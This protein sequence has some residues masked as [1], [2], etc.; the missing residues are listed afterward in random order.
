MPTGSDGNQNAPLP[1]VSSGT[2][3]S[4]FRNGSQPV[5]K[6]RNEAPRPVGNEPRSP[7]TIRRAPNAL[8]DIANPMPAGDPYTVM[9][10]WA[11]APQMM[12]GG[13]AGSANSTSTIATA[14]SA[15]MPPNDQSNAR[16]AA[17]QYWDAQ[18]EADNTASHVVVDGD[19]LERIA[20]RYLN[21]PQRGMEIYNLNRDVL[22]SPDVLPIGVEL[23]I[24][25][26][27]RR[28]SWDRQSRLPGIEDRSPL[29]AAASNNLVPV[30][31]ITSYDTVS[32]RAQLTAPI[33]AN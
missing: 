16:P 7:A 13:F 20:T 26:D 31:P 1:A 8:P 11:A 32:P 10:S 15:S 24:P 27:S 18:L 28:D 23:K 29:R 9:S 25:D 6:L 14:Y 33:P 2:A 30:R 17:A 5:A 19:S 3:A 4:A 21:D 12:P 22:A